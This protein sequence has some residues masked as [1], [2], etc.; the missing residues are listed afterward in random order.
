MVGYGK[1]LTYEGADALGPTTQLLSIERLP[2]GFSGNGQ[3]TNNNSADWIRTSPYPQNSRSSSTP[4]LLPV[5]VQ[6]NFVASPDVLPDVMLNSTSTGSLFEFIESTT[7]LDVLEPANETAD[8]PTS[9]PIKEQAGAIAGPEDDSGNNPPPI[10]MPGSIIISELFPLPPDNQEE[11]VELYNKTPANISLEGWWLED[12]SGAK[13]QLHGILASDTFQVIEKP[14]GNLNNGGDIVKLIASNE[15]I[16]DVVA[17]GDWNDGTP[18]NNAPAVKEGQSVIRLY[19]NDSNDDYTDFVLT[20]TP[21]R[22]KRNIQSLPVV[23]DDLQTA[24]EVNTTSN[25]NNISTT[26]IKEN[27]ASAKAYDKRQGGGI[28]IKVTGDKSIT[29]G[30]PAI[31]DAGDSEGNGK[32]KYLWDMGDGQLKEGD[33]IDYWYD[34]SGYFVVTLTVLDITQQRTK[35]IKIQVKEP[36]KP[37]SEIRTSENSTKSNHPISV[38]IAGLKELKANTTVSVTGIVAAEPGTYRGKKEFYIIDENEHEYGVS[39]GYKTVPQVQRGDRVT[40]TG[41]YT[42]TDGASHIVLSNPDWLVVLHNGLPPNPPTTTSIKIAGKLAG[43]LVSVQGE[44]V[45]TKKDLA[46]VDDAS[47]EIKINGLKKQKLTVRDGVR[48]TGVLVSTKDGVTLFPRDAQDIILMQPTSSE[49]ITNEKVTANITYK[50]NVKQKNIIL[51]GALGI[52]ILLSIFYFF[53]K[54]KKYKTPA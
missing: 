11:F 51:Y 13:T 35:K 25:N 30:E 39:V 27:K 20:D 8:A 47:G 6:Q 48:V 29:L 43:G 26:T 53:S 41:K 52:I 50:E 15:T 38:H 23:A 5:S 46:F 22:G 40:I 1:A 12:G 42:I 18:G 32:L 7:T 31:F 2:G 36:L 34:H 14:K 9:T 54:N 28:K 10:P 37:K 4:D 19:E 49:K 44:V 16:I 24:H 45:E 33:S 3:D 17:Y 21:T